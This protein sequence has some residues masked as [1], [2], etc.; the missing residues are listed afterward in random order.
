VLVQL[1]ALRNPLLVFIFIDGV[2]QCTG[3]RPSCARCLSRGLSCV[4]GASTTDAQPTPHRAALRRASH[5]GSSE[6]KLQSLKVSTASRIRMRRKG[7]APGSARSTEGGSLQGSIPVTSYGAAFCQ[8]IPP[9]LNDAISGYSRL[10]LPVEEYESPVEPLT[11]SS[12][13]TSSEIDSYQFSGMFREGC[14][15]YTYRLALERPKASPRS[16]L[17]R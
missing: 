13:D 3:A 16:F 7:S 8:D 11:P 4:Y 15:F 6:L 1:K 9:E 10:S 2:L 14:F 12:F 5:T 17:L